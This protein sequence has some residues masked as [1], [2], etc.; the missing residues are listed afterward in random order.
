MTK[1]L[2]AATIVIAIAAITA[3]ALVPTNEIAAVGPGSMAHDAPPV[4]PLRIV[5]GS[6]QQHLDIRAAATRFA[7]V[8]LELQPLTIVIHADRSGCEGA[9]GLYWPSEHGDRI[10]LCADGERL[11]LHEMA[12]AWGY[13]ALDDVERDDFVARTG[14]PTWKSHDH[15]HGKRATEVAA[16]AIAFGLM[17]Q[18]LAG[19]AARRAL[20]DL[21]HFVVLTG[22]E[23]PR[24]VEP[25]AEIAARPVP[26]I[27]PAIMA[28][29][30]VRTGG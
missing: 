3:D 14:M 10:D 5:G 20:S 24:L 28:M 19:D 26:T 7:A 13:H 23:S 21:D 18:P 16:D 27:D 11:V 22:F 4:E 1:F 30:A 12:H 2:A 8:G 15:P 29:Y 9:S 17:S 25:L 6:P